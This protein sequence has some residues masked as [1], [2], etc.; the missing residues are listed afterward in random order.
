MTTISQKTFQA[1]AS[2][3]GFEVKTVLTKGLSLTPKQK[4]DTFNHLA[5]NADPETKNSLLHLLNNILKNILK[6]G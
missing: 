4:L 3:A 1:L 2:T 6:K 5:K